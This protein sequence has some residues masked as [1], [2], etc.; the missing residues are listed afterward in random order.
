MKAVIYYAFRR[1]RR[2]FFWRATNKLSGRR[3]AVW[4]I[5]RKYKSKQLLALQNFIEC[6]AHRELLLVLNKRPI[7][8][9]GMTTVNEQPLVSVVVTTY[10][11]KPAML[12]R[13]LES[14]LGQTYRNIELIVVD[15][16]PADYEFRADVKTLCE[17]YG[18]CA[19]YI[20]HTTNQGAC[21]ARNTGIDAAGG[22]FIAFLDDDDEWLPTKIE[23]QLKLFDSDKIGLVYCA[24]YVVDEI[25]E[26][27]YVPKLKY[28][29]GNVFDA[30]MFG[31]FIGSTSFP[32]LR[33]DVVRNAGGFDV[34][35]PASQDYDLWLRIAEKY[36][37]AYVNEP[38]VNYFVHQGEQITKS[39]IS[40]RE[41]HLRIIEKNKA[42]L[43]KH[44]KA[45]SARLTILARSYVYDD[46]RT[47]S[48]L[49]LKAFL[50]YPLPQKLLIKT[51]YL[52]FNC[53]LF[54]KRGG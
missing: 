46:W 44:P 32:L 33:S 11:R 45:H 43:S 30:L 40:R 7:R 47:A 29:Q 28:F 23:K 39:R 18:S 27:A 25:C 1:G 10:K 5:K 24:R 37:V 51:V 42:Y 34:K 21:A 9:V 20:P 38:L 53:L 31:N 49:L 41:A 19:R 2:G 16:S 6:E 12:R 8:R 17:S 35:L 22:T 36:D 14:V 15:D 54:K 13:A 4:T 50:R 48:K 52:L 3:L 26:R